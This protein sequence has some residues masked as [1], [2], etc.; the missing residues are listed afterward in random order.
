MKKKPKINWEMLAFHIREA[1]ESLDTLHEFL[2]V[3]SGRRSAGTDETG[4]CRI[5]APHEEGQ[6]AAELAHVYHHLNFGWNTRFM[7]HETAE[8]DFEGHEKWPT[9]FTRYFREEAKA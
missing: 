2:E 1:K 9:C 6:M 3:R 8:S 4:F 5:R 7:D